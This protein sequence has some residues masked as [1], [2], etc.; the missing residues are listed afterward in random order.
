MPRG[1]CYGGGFD[2]KGMPRELTS[3]VGCE[4][5]CEHAA[6]RAGSRGRRGLLVGGDLR[7]GVEQ[8]AGREDFEP[9]VGEVLVL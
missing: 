1:P 5:K 9:G 6:R 7:E 3:T 8:I 2:L 4:Q